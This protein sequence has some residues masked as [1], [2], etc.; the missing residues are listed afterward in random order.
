MCL[1]VCVVC[2]YVCVCVCEYVCVYVFVRMCV[3]G[4]CLHSHIQDA[5]PLEQCISFSLFGR[6]H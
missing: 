4:V 2:L 1:Y 3:W 6:T 5:F